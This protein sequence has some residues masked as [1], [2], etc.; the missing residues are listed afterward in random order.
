M[1]DSRTTKRRALPAKLA[2]AAL[3]L[4][5]VFGTLELIARI[6][7]PGPF[8]FVDRNPYGKHSDLDHAHEPG[9]RGSWD[10]SWYEIN[11]LGARGPEWAPTFES[12]EFRVLALGDSCTFGKG[13]LQAESWPA[14]LETLLR[15]AVGTAAD[16][17]VL[18]AGVNGYS[19]R[20]Y[21]AQLERLGPTVR[22]QLVLIG[23]NLNDFPN[24][25]RAV[26]REVFQGKGNLRS[27][28]PTDLR[29]TLG[30]FALFRWLRATYYEW[31]R[32]RDWKLAERLAKATGGQDNQNV[33][34]FEREKERV[35]ALV[36]RARALGAQVAIFLMPYESQVYL[37]AFDA[38]PVERL[39]KV[40]AELDVV[41]VD[42]AVPFRDHARSA[43][44]STR[45]FL[46]GDRYHPTAEG[47]RIV[48]QSVLQT[49]AEHR[50]LPISH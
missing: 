46:R 44:S 38:T 5:V 6:A 2:I 16:V 50:W 18:N 7:E 24:V 1:V 47:Y 34:R 28:I 27:M 35:R 45:L 20:Q 30:R 32:E 13:V 41:F 39:R 37:D 49:I 10:G 19:G 33:P 8:S 40:C 48:A 42:L 43:E 23:Y 25:I 3:S 36:D 4:I 29:N 22:P 26:D 9:F 21:L 14:Q 17:R 31:N 11:S 12:E 15:G